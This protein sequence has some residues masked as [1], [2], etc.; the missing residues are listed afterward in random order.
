M[1]YDAGGFSALLVPADDW[2]QAGQVPDQPPTP[3]PTP[4]PRTRGQGGCGRPLR[5][6]DCGGISRY[7]P[8]PPT[9]DLP[10]P[11]TVPVASF[12]RR[13]EARG[14]AAF[15]NG[16]GLDIAQ[17]S[18]FW[19]S[20]VAREVGGELT[21]HRCQWDIEIWERGFLYRVEVKY[22][23]EYR[24]TGPPARQIMKW[25]WPR[26]KPS[27]VKPAEILVLIGLDW[28]DQVWSW[29]TVAEQVAVCPAVHVMD[30]RTRQF[31]APSKLSGLQVPPGRIGEAVRTFARGLTIL[32][33]GL[34]RSPPL[35]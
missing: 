32:R 34:P 1:A 13:A 29:V 5:R 8:P 14:F 23:R 33:T 4:S 28:D 10:G 19:E 26:G 20:V 24:E 31:D 25:P 18:L 16:L 22:A 9:L 17:T 15:R 3:T 35:G 30:P 7:I 12:L 27:K 21:A 11:Y 2:P 6:A